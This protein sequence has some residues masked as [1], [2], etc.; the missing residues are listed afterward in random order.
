MAYWVADGRVGEQFSQ[1]SV[2]V[3]E[4]GK[5]RVDCYNNPSF[6][7][8]IDPVASTAKGRGMFHIAKFDVTVMDNHIRVDDLANSSFWLCL[9][10]R[11]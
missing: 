5:I 1:L 4:D 2:C 3:M 9:K 10:R 8:L 11:V 7:I 6:W